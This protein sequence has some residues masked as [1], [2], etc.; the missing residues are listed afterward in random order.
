MLEKI[1]KLF[2]KRSVTMPDN[3]ENLENVEET[4][5]ENE[6]L[7]ASETEETQIE[8]ETVETKPED[9]VEETVVEETEIVESVETKTVDF[10]KELKSLEDKWN[11]KFE[12]S[13][14]EFKTKMAEKDKVIEQQNE[15]I[16][17][18]EKRIP[19]SPYRNI[20]TKEQTETPES[21]KRNNVVKG[22]YGN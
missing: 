18:L 3:K 14:E 7:E 22:F 6:N 13:F 5:I 2:K 15:K 10:E 19:N 9:T 17:E 4:S 12:S 21:L 16:A 1:K 20:I 11:L 8:T